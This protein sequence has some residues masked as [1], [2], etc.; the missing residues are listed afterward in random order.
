MNWIWCLVAL[1]L[2]G[3]A[4]ASGFFVARF[5]GE[6]GHPTGNSPT[7]IYY[8]PAALSLGKGTRLFLD[9]NIVT[10]AFEYVRDPAAI[11][12]IREAGDT[13][14]GTPE[15]ALDA[16]SGK[17][18]LDNF[19]VSPFIGVT[20]DLGG[21]VPGLQLGFGFFAPFG[22]ASAY[23]QNESYVGNNAYPG[24]VDGPQRWWAIEG[25]IR[26]I[27]ITAAASYHIPAARLSIG[28]AFNL[29]SSEV[30]TARARNGDGTDHMVSGD[31]ELPVEGRALVD[32]DSRD[33]T[34]G[35]GVMWQPTDEV[36]VGVSYQSAPG[37]DEMM[38][39]GTGV[40]IQGSAPPSEPKIE[41]FQSMPDVWQFGVRYTKEDNFE[42]RLAG[43]YIGWSALTHQCGAD[44]TVGQNCDDFSKALFVIQ[45]GWN[46]A[47]A[48]RGGASYWT[49][50]AVELLFGAG[51]DANAV[52]DD[53]VEPA[54]YD[55]DKY[56]LT[57]GVRLELLDDALA[58]AMTYTQV[59]YNDRVI[60]PRGHAEG[61]TS[62]TLPESWPAGT[63]NPD[64]AGKYSQ[65][66]GVLN[67]S[68]QYSF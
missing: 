8:N 34:F 23:E 65:S 66:I 7:A 38:L 62:T 43:N 13:A 33:Y 9:A 59:I 30:N 44:P 55:T 42:V 67:T 45:R 14:N 32:V 25:S 60:A 27:Y 46:D 4:A 50:P 58:L 21:A 39:E 51:Y 53:V 1:F 29:V 6:Q 61:A 63:R 41:M 20:T 68:V 28:A 18:T 12:N 49:S 48:V 54:L 2:A 22:G 31:D 5:G 35:A 16:N 57:G 17:A 52:P 37:G 10:R 15:S 64:A 47:F 56:T 19:L 40:L 24:A 3:E 36:F 11:D 26:H